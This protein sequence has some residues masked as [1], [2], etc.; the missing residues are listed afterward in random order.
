MPATKHT[1]CAR[2][3]ALCLRP[4]FLR[5]EE[6]VRAREKSENR[7]TIGMT[8]CVQRTTER[9]KV[10]GATRGTMCP[11][12]RFL[13]N[14]E[15][16]R[17]DERHYVPA[18][19]HTACARW[20]ALCLRPLFLRMEK[21]VRA[22][23]KSENRGTIGGS[24]TFKG[25][26]ERRGTVGMTSRVQ[27]TTERRKVTG[28]TRGTTCPRPRFLQKGEKRPARRE[29]LRARDETHCVCA[30]GRSVPASVIS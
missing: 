24:F 21:A 28:A 10:T 2:R 16:L 13:Q 23:E 17:R 14:G 9:R 11:R 12:P 3:G 30:A 25:P 1:A 29:A 18:T 20:G 5:M 4:L 8:S 6:A 19:K 26:P 27:R 22:S 7:G 15:I